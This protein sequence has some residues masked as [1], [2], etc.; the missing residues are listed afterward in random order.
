M[1]ETNLRNDALQQQIYI[2]GVG[3]LKQL[4]VLSFPMESVDRS[5]ILL[6]NTPFLA[7][8]NATSTASFKRETDLRMDFP[9]VSPASPG[10]CPSTRSPT[11]PVKGGEERKTIR[12]IYFNGGFGH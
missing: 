4:G 2:T 3:S 1:I 7:T 9:I 10:G 8:S 11:P 12:F 5:A 6:L